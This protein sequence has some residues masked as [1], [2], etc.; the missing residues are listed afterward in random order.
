MFG[1]NHHPSHPLA[2]NS[3]CRDVQGPTEKK[4]KI[5]FNYSRLF[6]NLLSKARCAGKQ[7]KGVTPV[8]GRVKSLFC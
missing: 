2:H 6:I 3:F 8:P 4:K 1:T 7:M 5:T